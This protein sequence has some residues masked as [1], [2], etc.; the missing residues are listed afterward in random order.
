[1]VGV[2]V[3]PS[4]KGVEDVGFRKTGSVSKTLVAS[5]I[6]T[7]SYQVGWVPKEP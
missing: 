5:E 4:Q 1:M 6:L 2:M 3:V 7:V